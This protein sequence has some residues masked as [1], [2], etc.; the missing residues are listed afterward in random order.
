MRGRERHAEDRVGPE[1]RL[2]RRAVELDQGAVE[3]LPGRRLAPRERARRSRRRRWPTARVDAL[4]A[5]ALAA[6]AQLGGLELARR[7][8]RRHGRRPRRRSAARPRPRPSGCRG[9]RGSGGRGCRSIWLILAVRLPAAGTRRARQGPVLVP[10][11]ALR[12]FVLLAVAH[13]ESGRQS[14]L[15]FHFVF[16]VLDELAERLLV[17]GGR[18]AAALIA[19]LGLRKAL[20]VAGRGALDFEHVVAERRLHR[21]AEHVA[22]R[23]EQASSSGSASWPLTTRQQAAFGLAGR[24]DR[25]LL[26]DA[27]EALAR[28]DFFFAALRPLRFSSG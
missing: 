1:P 11:V 25:N 13:H 4:A 24:V 6:V 22:W 17:L 5:P 19:R 3:R 21:P 12:R 8:A 26:G 20:L 14:V 15:A 16:E 28:F 10:V 2:V 23:G 9:C 7:G 27:R 18:S